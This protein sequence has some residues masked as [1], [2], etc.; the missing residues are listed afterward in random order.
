M[1]K[2]EN[3]WKQSL[4]PGL[5]VLPD[6]V[7]AEEEAMLLDSV[8]SNDDLSFDT[9]NG[10]RRLQLLSITICYFVFAFLENTLKHRIVKHYG[11]EF[12]YGTNNVDA[13]KPLSRK[14]PN[15]CS[16][17]WP[18]LQANITALQSRSEPEQLTVNIYQPGQGIPPHVDTHS[19]FL[20]PICSLSLGSEVVM[21][22]RQPTSGSHVNVLLPRRS[23]LIISGESRY[24]WT[25]GITPRKFDIVQAL[26]GL[27]LSKRSQRF[28][29]TFRWLQTTPCVCSF[30]GLCDTAK[31]AE[32]SRKRV[33]VESPAKLEH[34]N[35][36]K[37]YDEIA[38]HFS[39][40]RHSP[41]PEV[42][43]FVR[44]LGA[45]SLLADI[46][47]GNG[48][49]LTLDDGLYK[50]GGDR[51]IGLLNVCRERGLNVFQCDCLYVPLR[52]GSMDGCISIAVVH[53]LAS[54]VKIIVIYDRY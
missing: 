39:E 42:E 7:S 17:L 35:V 3:P 30:P 15:S 53:H 34:E 21:E 10:E 54:K 4:P 2:V 12:L 23:M 6:F 28:S 16:I 29:F 41:W 13:S 33:L 25:H 19:A 18:R 37:V 50:I 46:G 26:S 43:A 47:C 20:D 52:D 8:N 14:I 9:E 45:G 40:T 51:S 32:E 49:Y 24:G 38:S 36:H 44:S 22:F 11:F 27:S 5:I 48:K 31:R 1:P